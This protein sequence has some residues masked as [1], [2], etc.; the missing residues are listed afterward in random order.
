MKIKFVLPIVLSIA[1]QGFC[2]NLMP[3][4]TRSLN[5]LKYEL[6]AYSFK[7]QENL[8][9]SYALEL[10]GIYQLKSSI[11]SNK[12][13]RDEYLTRL[14]D[15]AKGHN[16][17]IFSQ[18]FIDE[19]FRYGNIFDNASYEKYLFPILPQL[20]KQNLCDSY[21][22]EGHYYEHIENNPAYALKV[23]QSGISNC[24]LDYK[25]D[26]IMS[27]YNKLQYTSSSKSNK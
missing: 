4:Y 23:Y 5:D 26:G 18:I 3:D 20:I 8:F 21:L 2:S 16:E 12:E 11:Y 19:F 17:P 1:V 15:F 25:R 14:R 13:N 10:S 24:T 9:N 7:T 22:L 6:P 27:R